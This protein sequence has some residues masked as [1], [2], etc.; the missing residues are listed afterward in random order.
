MRAGYLRKCK[1]LLLPSLIGILFFYCIPFVRVIYYSLVET[2]LA[3]SGW[4]SK[5]IRFF[6]KTSISGWQ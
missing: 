1:L 5:I 6:L 3:K 4:V 2:S